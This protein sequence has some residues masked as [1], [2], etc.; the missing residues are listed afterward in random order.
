MNS[1][2]KSSKI[3]FQKFFRMKQ[4]EE[5]NCRNLVMQIQKLLFANMKII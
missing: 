3:Q 4:E 2:N 1:F 5:K